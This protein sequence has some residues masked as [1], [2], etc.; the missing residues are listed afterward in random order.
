MWIKGTREKS[1]QELDSFVYK[2]QKQAEGQF[3]TYKKN[4]QNIDRETR[5]KLK[6]KLLNLQGL[7]EINEKHI[8]SLQKKLNPV[9][10]E[11]ENASLI[12]HFTGL[13][14]QIITSCRLNKGINRYIYI[15]L[16]YIHLDQ[17]NNAKPQKSSPSQP[18]QNTTN[19]QISSAEIQEQFS[20]T[21]LKID[22]E[23]NGQLEQH[24]KA[25]QES[26]PKEMIKKVKGYSNVYRISK[27]DL[28]RCKD[29]L[30]INPFRFWA[31]SE[32]DSMLL[33]TLMIA[34]N[35]EDCQEA[36]EYAGTNTYHH[37]QRRAKGIGQ[38]VFNQVFKKHPGRI[39]HTDTDHIRIAYDRPPIVHL[40]PLRNLAKNFTF[41]KGQY[42]LTINKDSVLYKLSRGENNESDLRNY[43]LSGDNDV[44]SER[45]KIKGNYQSWNNFF[46]SS[47]K[48]N[49]EKALDLL[50]SQ[51]QKSIL[52]T[53]PEDT[54]TVADVD[55]FTYNPS[56]ENKISVLKKA[57]EILNNQA[58]FDKF[59]K[60]KGVLQ[61]RQYFNYFFAQIH[62]EI[63]Y[64]KQLESDP[65]IKKQD[66]TLLHQEI[67]RLLTIYDFFLNKHLTVRQVV[68]HFTKKEIENF[69]NLIRDK[70]HYEDI[71][72]SI[73]KNLGYKN[74]NT[75]KHLEYI[76]QQ[77]DNH[78]VTQILNL[79]DAQIQN[80]QKQAIT[81][82]SI[83][84]FLQ[85]LIEV[86]FPNKKQNPHKNS[87]APLPQ[88]EGSIKISTTLRIKEFFYNLTFYLPLSSL[89]LKHLNPANYREKTGYK[90]DSLYTS[91]REIQESGVTKEIREN[92]GLEYDSAR[93]IPSK[94]EAKNLVY[95]FRKEKNLMGTKEKF[96]YKIKRN[97]FIW[98][99]VCIVV[100]VITLGLSITSRILIV[101]N[102][103]PTAP[104]KNILD[105]FRGF[106]E[107]SLLIFS[108]DTVLDLVILRALDFVV[109]TVH[110]IDKYLLGSIIQSTLRIMTGVIVD[111]V[112]GIKDCLKTCWQSLIDHELKGS[113]I[114]A[115]DNIK[116]WTKEL[117]AD[118]VKIIPSKIFNY[119]RNKISTPEERE[120]SIGFNIP[121]LSLFFNLHK[122]IKKWKEKRANA[123]AILQKIRP[124]QLNTEMALN[125]ATVNSIIV[126]YPFDSLEK[127]CS[128]LQTLKPLQ[129]RIQKIHKSF[130]KTNQSPKELEKHL[131]KIQ[132]EIDK[133]SKTG[134]YKQEL[135]TFFAKL[136]DKEKEYFINTSN[137]FK[138]K[139]LARLDLACTELEKTLP[140][141]KKQ[142]LESIR[143]HIKK[144]GVTADGKHN[145]K[146][147]LLNEY[148]QLYRKLEDLG[149]RESFENLLQF[150]RQ[151]E[152]L[153]KDLIDIK[154]KKDLI[155]E[156]KEGYIQTFLLDTAINYKAVK[157]EIR[158][159]KSDISEINYKYLI[160]NFLI[161][162][163]N[164]SSAKQG[165]ISKSDLKRKIKILDAVI[166][167]L[168]AS[169]LEAARSIA[170]PIFN[171]T[172]NTLDSTKVGLELYKAI[173]EE[174][175]QKINH[176]HHIDPIALALLTAKFSRSLSD[177]AIFLKKGIA[178]SESSGHEFSYLK[179]YLSEYGL[180][181][182]SDT[183]PEAKELAEELV[184]YTGIKSSTDVAIKR[185]SHFVKD[186]QSPIKLIIAGAGSYA[187]I[188][189]GG[190]HIIEYAAWP[191][192]KLEEHLPSLHIH[193]NATT[194]MGGVVTAIY[195]H[196]ETPR[197][198]AVT[199]CSANKTLQGSTAAE[200]HV[201]GTLNTIISLLSSLLLINSIKTYAA[202][203]GYTQQEKLRQLYIPYFT[204]ISIAFDGFIIASLLLE[205]LPKK[206]IGMYTI[207]VAAVILSFLPLAVFIYSLFVPSEKHARKHS[208]HDESKRNT[209]SVYPK[210]DNDCN[211]D[212]ISSSTS[213]YESCDE[214]KEKPT[215]VTKRTS[216][217]SLTSTTALNIS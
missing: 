191:L 129:E 182:L 212:S 111:L 150:I 177:A 76:K 42:R 141:N 18:A 217:S 154:H 148:N 20:A 30:L 142:K 38:N 57:L 23:E 93:F 34:N 73:N 114:I 145:N 119:F 19:K 146:T 140:N 103:I 115:A 55:F 128:D 26:F 49:R 75:F 213:H 186:F 181:F 216:I 4:S 79:N 78:P 178:P 94:H 107:T 176:S 215:T 113:L 3:E 152:Q 21:K 101:L 208:E 200:M 112:V 116:T 159:D 88:R 24:V 126:N 170:E 202:E 121:V 41:K 59:T 36:Y 214:N 147:Q 130:N 77:I 44:D 81:D 17:Y 95:D 156:N 133:S 51:Q 211:N 62:A 8:K 54:I 135:D 164:S 174:F 180:K 117:T 5:K 10:L 12:A 2:I 14:I 1:I 127:A 106:T 53:I 199:L 43:G 162:N 196:A 70:E 11:K 28:Q 83:K 168:E 82:P 167:K 16:D 207:I 197:D 64:L 125:A 92:L 179:D 33:T 31:N 56:T 185:F 175:E 108:I 13:P 69:R 163:T 40:D 32:E 35:S 105:E 85:E 118:K 100:G 198:I 80:L 90:R 144:I 6:D 171:L 123:K 134:R 165:L 104:I 37:D 22:K 86:K 66:F 210:S 63:S 72:K 71:C 153:H 193:E 143:T 96:I 46:E 68:Y 190:G 45:Y 109:L 160:D 61:A 98:L 102:V 48:K 91:N 65:K 131:E 206:K 204:I 15:D 84:D 7:K 205:R 187:L 203:K 124:H 39:K 87:K 137:T 209:P 25:L 29:E 188:G 184:L 97:R 138:R 74:S 195:I 155:L 183:S 173:L 194:V 149:Y 132:L 99:S 52:R 189:L 67:N 192:E 157:E 89:W 169:K 58:F 201:K 166:K 60:G 120:E 27:A 122:N 139:Y 161:P 136:R 151:K 158:K 110:Y 50:I 47:L 9:F 172:G